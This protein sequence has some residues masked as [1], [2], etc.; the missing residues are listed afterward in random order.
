MRFA[1]LNPKSITT[2]GLA[3]FPFA[4][5][6]SENLF[7]FLFLRLLRCFSSAGL[8]TCNYLFITGWQSI[9]LPGFPI[10]KSAGLC[11]F[12]AI[13]SLSQLVTSFFG[14]WCQGILHVLFFAWPSSAQV[15][16][17]QQLFT[18]ASSLHSAS[19]FPQKFTFAGALSLRFASPSCS[20]LV[21]LLFRTISRSPCDHFVSKSFLFFPR[22]WK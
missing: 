19:S 18:A 21:S 6:Y 10:R 8:P 2:L 15:S 7:W 9:A 14:S 3:S 1:V 22:F 17:P 20:S 16:L 4:R 12:A 5:R 11:L 13:R